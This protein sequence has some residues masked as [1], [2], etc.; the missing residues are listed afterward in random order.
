MDCG[1]LSLLASDEL[2]WPD[3]L[4]EL[5][6]LDELPPLIVSVTVAPCATWSPA[7]LSLPFTDMAVTVAESEDDPLR[8]AVKPIDLSVAA[9]LSYVMPITEGKPTV[10]GPVDT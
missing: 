4:D 6:G 1:E 3:E 8:A 10:L 5:D 2:D 7:E 9:A